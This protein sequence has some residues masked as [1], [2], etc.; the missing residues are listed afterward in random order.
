M[1]ITKEQI[2]KFMQ[3]N[4]LTYLRLRD[5]NLEFSVDGVHWFNTEDTFV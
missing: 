5:G 1:I 4:G 2:I 3:E